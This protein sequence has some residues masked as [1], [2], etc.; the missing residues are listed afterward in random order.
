ME[1]VMRGVAVSGYR[2]KAFGIILN[3]WKPEDAARVRD[4]VMKYSDDRHKELLAGPDEIFI[5]IMF[6]NCRKTPEQYLTDYLA[7]LAK[8][9]AQERILDVQIRMAN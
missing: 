2:E 8:A 1:A 5:Y 7:D 4:A 3:G 6:G 9:F